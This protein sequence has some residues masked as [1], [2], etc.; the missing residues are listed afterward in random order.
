MSFKSTSFLRSPALAFMAF[1]AVKYVKS[2]LIWVFITML[3][4]F[5]LINAANFIVI[6]NLQKNISPCM[7]PMTRWLSRLE[8]YH[9]AI[10][11]LML[12]QTMDISP[13][14]CQHSL[15]RQT[16]NCDHWS[17]NIIENSYP[18]ICSYNLLA[19]LNFCFLYRPPNLMAKQRVVCQVLPDDHYVDQSGDLSY[20]EHHLL[21]HIRTHLPPLL[22]MFQYATILQSNTTH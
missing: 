11:Y 16:A 15:L 17:P 7:F 3:I 8:T 18:S 20:S 4:M 2:C 21:F 19:A 10:K 5:F 9:A 22:P 12:K 14:R 6:S 13:Y 1:F